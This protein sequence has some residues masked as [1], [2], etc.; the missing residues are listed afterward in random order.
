V[1]AM[2]LVVGETLQAWSDKLDV[3]RKAM[4]GWEVGIVTRRNTK[5]LQTVASSARSPLDA[6]KVPTGERQGGVAAGSGEAQVAG[7]L[8]LPDR[9][10]L[11][12]RSP[13]RGEGQPSRAP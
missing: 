6:D 12:D 7:G 11:I 13:C 3:A 10:R 5:G 1:Y 2:T 4:A 9:R 8:S